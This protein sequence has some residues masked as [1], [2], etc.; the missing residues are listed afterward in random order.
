MFN[1]KTVNRFN[2][3]KEDSRYFPDS[4]VVNLPV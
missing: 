3:G 1:K 4:E 2:A